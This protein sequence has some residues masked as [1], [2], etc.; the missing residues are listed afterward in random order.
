VPV[1]FVGIVHQLREQM[2]RTHRISDH[3]RRN[4]S[5]PRSVFHHCCR[6]PARN[7]SRARTPAVDGCRP[8]IFRMLGIRFLPMPTLHSRKIR[9]ADGVHTGRTIVGEPGT[10]SAAERIGI[11]AATASFGG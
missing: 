4:T 7:H 6:R 9:T 3:N 5:V 8:Y 11:R 10:P 1:V 2:P